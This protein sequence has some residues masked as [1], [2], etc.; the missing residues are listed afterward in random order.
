M[1]EFGWLVF[2]GM[3]VGEERSIVIGRRCLYGEACG[4]LVDG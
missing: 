2:R 1:E 4:M 3:V